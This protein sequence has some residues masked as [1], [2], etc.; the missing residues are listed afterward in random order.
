MLK[1]EGNPFQCS[2]D[3]TWMKDWILNNSDTIE[4]YKNIE[5]EMRGGKHV[6]IIQMN[7]VDM[8]CLPNGLWKIVG[9]LF[10]EIANLTFVSRHTVCCNIKN[11]EIIL[12]HMLY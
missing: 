12:T 2:C 8:G 4:N 3:N 11:N 7:E 9:K 10:K 6:P 5:C 1:I